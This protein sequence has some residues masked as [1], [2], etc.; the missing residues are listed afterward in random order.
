MIS[1]VKTIS[2]VNEPA[3]QFRVPQPRSGFAVLVI[4]WVRS[5]LGQPP[6]TRAVLSDD[7]RKQLQHDRLFA[8]RR[9]ERLSM[10]IRPPY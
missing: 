9:I 4:R 6:K 3:E 1:N 2:A 7:A 8:Q 5:L 10:T